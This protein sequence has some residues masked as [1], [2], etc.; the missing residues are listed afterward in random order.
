MDALDDLLATAQARTGLRDFG[1]DAFREGLGVLVGALRTEAKLNAVG[2]VMLPELI[3]NHLSQRLQIEDWYKRYPEI[4]DERIDAPLIALGL[5]RTGSKALSNLLAEDPEARSLRRWEAHAP[6]PPPSTVPGPDPRIAASVPGT[7]TG[8]E[9]CQELMG[10]SFAAH[11]FQAFA[12]VPTYSDWLLGADLTAT[13]RYERRALKLLQWGYPTRTW[14]LKCPSHLL[15]ID[16]LDTVFPDARFVMTHRD[17]TDVMVAVADLYGEVGRQFSVDVDPHYLG[18]LNV[19]H[20]ATG[21]ERL[22]RFRATHGDERFHD[23]EF[24]D[25]QRDP[26]GQV[27]RLYAWLGE[28]VTDGFA[29][30]LRRWWVANGGTREANI[31]PDAAEFGIDRDEVRVR[32]AA[33]SA[34]IPEWTARWRHP[35][36]EWRPDASA[37]G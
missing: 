3:V 7:P 9:E 17:P 16:H 12:Y 14:R 11:Y 6:C 4:D 36:S 29:T 1:D 37:H 20:W 33:Y 31:H 18:R 5:P 8:P 22:L 25:M 10:L 27:R 26:L 30:G 2:E 15:W 19:E 35:N 21:M 34:K 28:P 13:Y 23:I 32:F 24:R